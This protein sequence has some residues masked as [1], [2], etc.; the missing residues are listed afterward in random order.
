MN[1]EL[2]VYYDVNSLCLMHS[3]C[4]SPIVDCNVLKSLAQ[5]NLP[6]IRLDVRKAGHSNVQINNTKP[7][8]SVFPRTPAWD[9][10]HHLR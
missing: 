5:R 4:L 7:H 1:V 6:T 8:C 2:L 3:P 9:F 10:L